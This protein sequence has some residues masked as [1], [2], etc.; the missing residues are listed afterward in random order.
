[1]VAVAIAAVVLFVLASAATAG[2]TGGHPLP[3]PFEPDSASY[4]VT[5]PAAV[6]VSAFLLVS[7]AIPL[8]VFVAASVS[9]L[10]FLGVR[11]AGA[12]IALAGGLLASAATLVGAFAMWALALAPTAPAG[13]VHAVHLFAFATTGVG[14]AAPFGLFVA[15]LAVSGGL[16]QLLPRWLMWSGV[17]IAVLAELATLG[18]VVPGGVYLIPT[19]RVLGLSWMVG[20]AVALPRTRATPVSPSARVVPLPLREVQ[21]A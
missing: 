19:T 16:H 10:V 5:Y 13:A 1:L 20:V 12:F 2:L 17:A 18:L 4:F 9:R 14:F 15:G 7:A 3:S 21:Q 8:V 6:R 11:A